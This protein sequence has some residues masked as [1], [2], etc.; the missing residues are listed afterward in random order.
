[1]HIAAAMGRKKLTKILV[2]AGTDTNIRNKQ[3]ETALD[4][5]V[6]KHLSDI[7]TILECNNIQ[8]IISDLEPSAEESREVRQ[9]LNQ[10]EERKPSYNQ[11]EE[12]RQSY[13]QPDERRQSYCQP[14]EKRPSE[15]RRRGRN[16]DWDL[17]K[18]DR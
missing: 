16:K 17:F 2:E 4:I 9:I 15:D 12:R 5:A 13:K 18:G 14:E 8:N 3:N 6:R 10:S 11:S 7:V 1:M